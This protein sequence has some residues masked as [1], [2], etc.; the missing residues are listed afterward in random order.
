MNGPYNGFLA[1][2]SG[3][4]QKTGGNWGNGPLP[5][6]WTLDTTRQGGVRPWDAKGF[7]FTSGQQ[8]YKPPEGW[9]LGGDRSNPVQPPRGPHNPGLAMGRPGNESPNPFSLASE[10]ATPSAFNGSGWGN[11]F[12]DSPTNTGNN[13]IGGGGSNGGTGTTTPTQYPAYGQAPIMGTPAPGFGADAW[14]NVKEDTSPFQGY[15]SALTGQGDNQWQ[16]FK[17]DNPTEDW[18]RNFNEIS[19]PYARMRYAYG[20]GKG[21]YMSPYLS[22]AGFSNPQIQTMRNAFGHNG[23]DATQYLSAL[24]IDQG[25]GVAGTNFEQHGNQ[26]WKVSPPQVVNGRYVPATRQLVQTLGSG[27]TM[28][29]SSYQNS[30]ATRNLYGDSTNSWIQRSSSPQSFSGQGN[31]QMNSTPTAIASRAAGNGWTWK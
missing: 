6:G 19:D 15:Q 12:V 31:N 24:G 25:K 4:N 14:Q 1:A 7:N 5:M 21:E 30:A 18:Q 17:F 8:Y 3:G 27:A 16:N 10:A 22:Q 23:A 2:G 29:D 13:P 11:Q 28:N 20:A 26:L 9:T